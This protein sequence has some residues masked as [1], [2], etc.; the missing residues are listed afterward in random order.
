MALAIV[1]TVAS[2]DNP[3]FSSSVVTLS[4]TVPAG[5]EL[6]VIKT[7]I[8]DFDFSKLTSLT[9]NGSASGIVL[10]VTS[11]NA[12]NNCTRIWTIQN[13]TSGTHDLVWTST[14]SS[15]NAGGYVAECWAGGIDGTTPVSA[16]AESSSGTAT[17]SLTTS[18]SVA[19]G[20]IATGLS[21]AGGS[22]VVLSGQTVTSA[23]VNGH[24]ASYRADSTGFGVTFTGTQQISQA[25]IALNPVF[26]GVSA[27][28]PGATLTGTSTIVPGAASAS[29][30]GS[31]PGAALT[32][33]STISPGAASALNYGTITSDVFR[34][35]GSPTALTALAIPHVTV[36]RMTDGALVLNLTAQ[37]TNGS[38]QLALVSTSIITGVWYMLGTWNADGSARGFKAYLAT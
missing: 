6:M 27:T 11:H 1:G 16:V 35:W 17:G 12:A 15:N 18:I 5:T 23:L 2:L 30:A 3:S 29:A 31:A 37:T 36:Q 9:Y 10:Q 7:C 21:Y 32:G 8:N 34:A 28:A 24:V 4:V 14:T 19:S 13:P 25:V 33:V 38:G 22:P 26:S 20:G